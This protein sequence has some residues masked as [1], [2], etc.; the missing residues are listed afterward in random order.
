MTAILAPEQPNR[1]G[2]PSHPAVFPGR[3]EDPG[4]EHAVV[5]MPLIEPADGPGNGEVPPELAERG[6]RR[7]TARIAAAVGAGAEAAWC[8]WADAP[9]AYIALDQQLPGH[10]G[11]DAAL[12]WA[13]ESGW[14]V[15]VETGCGEDLL[16]TAELGGDVLPAPEAVATWFRAVLAGKSADTHRRPASAESTDIVHRLA[17]WARDEPI[18]DGRNG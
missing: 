16:I 5:L 18:L 7:Y 8:E 4:R 13:A 3:T 12:I 15:A 17:N 10:P 1:T 6:L 2:R 9:S 11:R 14:S